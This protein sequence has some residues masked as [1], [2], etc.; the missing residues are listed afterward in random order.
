MIFHIFT[1][2]KNGPDQLQN[3]WA[4][5]S[6][7]ITE[8]FSTSYK[9]TGKLKKKVK[10]VDPETLLGLMRVSSDPSSF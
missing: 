2:L 1:N 9:I 6:D 3:Y 5:I 10:E 4:R 7:C 8:I